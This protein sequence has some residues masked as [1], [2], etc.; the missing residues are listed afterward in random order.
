MEVGGAAEDALSRW[1][2]G[3]GEEPD[4]RYS[5]ANE[6]T[7]LAWVR[8]ALTLLAGAVAL[9]SLGVPDQRWLRTV[10][11]VTLVLLGGLITALAF[12]RWARVEKAMR[13]GSPLPAFA[14]GLG[15]TIVVV[16]FAA[17][18]AVALGLSPG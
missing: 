3:S 9:H 18:L 12:V 11:V 5:L 2:Y 15:T 8:T 13:T 17:L 4:P 6:R 10:V 1:V 7:F 14:L 16:L